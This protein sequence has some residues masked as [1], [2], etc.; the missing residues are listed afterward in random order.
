VY[1]YAFTEP[2]SFCLLVAQVLVVHM[3]D[4]L[5]G[6]FGQPSSYFYRGLVRT[7]FIL[8]KRVNKLN[9]VNQRMSTT[10]KDPRGASIPPPCRSTPGR[11]DKVIR[12][13]HAPHNQSSGVVYLNSRPAVCASRGRRGA[14]GRSLVCKGRQVDTPQRR[15]S[16]VSR[17]R[18]G[19]NVGVGGIG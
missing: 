19:E 17:G 4:R 15:Q 14:F 12:N 13:D 10:I 2:S 16:L 9:L 7:A 8:G 6:S 18:V 5:T 3:R 1:V 11:L